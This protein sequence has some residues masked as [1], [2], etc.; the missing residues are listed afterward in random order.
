[1]ALSCIARHA[2]PPMRGRSPR[3]R[4]DGTRTQ[5][6]GGMILV[7]ACAE[8]GWRGVWVWSG[9]GQC[10]CGCWGRVVGSLRGPLL[11]ADGA[12]AA[13]RRCILGVF[14][15]RLSVRVVGRTQQ[16]R[17]PPSLSSL[18]RSLLNHPPPH[19]H[20]PPT[21]HPHTGLDGKVKVWDVFGSKK[22]MRTYLGHSKG[23]KDINFTNDGSRF[24]SVGY[25]KNIRLWDTETGQVSNI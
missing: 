4:T 1:M 23:V 6:S 12:C 21:L 14:E 16:R 15:S 2:S 9:C 3:V 13:V 10:G 22:C 8:C 17:P 19:I 20:T 5:P 11:P 7:G 24:V 18:S 25:D